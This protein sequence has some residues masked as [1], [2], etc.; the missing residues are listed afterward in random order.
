M[1]RLAAAESAAFHRAVPINAVPNAFRARIGIDHRLRFRLLPDRG[2][3][4]D[5]N[6]RLDFKRRIKT[7]G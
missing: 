4:V 6:N 7:L 2:Q 3:V 5:L 1:G